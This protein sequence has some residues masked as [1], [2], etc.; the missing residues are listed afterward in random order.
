MVE[1]NEEKSISFICSLEENIDE[2][3]PIEFINDELIRINKIY[4]KSLLIDNRKE[5]K[6]DEEKKEKMKILEVF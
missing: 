4:N 1:P 5:N 6:T 3:N 2:I